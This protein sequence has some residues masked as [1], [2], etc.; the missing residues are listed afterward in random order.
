MLRTGGETVAPLE[1]EDALRD[2]PAIAEVAVVGIP[3][4]DV[5]RDR[6]RGRRRGTRTRGRAVDVDALRA[7]CHDRLAAYK[8]PRRVAVVDALPRTAATGQV[9]RTLIVERIA[10]RRL[11]EPARLATQ[12]IAEG[13]L[14]DL[15]GRRTRELLD[16]TQ[17]LG[18]LLAG[19]AGGVEMG[20]DGVER[21]QFAPGQRPHERAGVLPQP[22]VGR[23]HDRDLG[24][25]G[26][27]QDELLDLERA[28]RS[29]RRG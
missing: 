15:A 3:D 21:R 27:A 9:Q 4:A 28:R 8:Q 25:P 5:G 11:G 12:P 1:V 19:E 26:Q 22:R 16:R 10:Q 2:H 24:D 29:H 7:H 6:V 14:L 13:E 20:A 23:G 17:V 18:P